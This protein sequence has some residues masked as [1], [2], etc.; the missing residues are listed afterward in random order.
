MCPVCLAALKDPV[1]TRCGHRF[2]KVCLRQCVHSSRYGRCPVDNMWFDQRR[3]VFCDVAIGREVLS[4]TVRC[5]YHPQDCP[6]TGEL[7]ALQRHST[8][9]PH[10][11]VVC[12][13]E[14]G[15][16]C[17]RLELVDHVLECPRRLAV[18]Q[19]CHEEVVIAELPKHQL[20]ACQKFPVNCTICG[21]TGILRGDI[22]R[23]INLMSGNCPLVVVKCPYEHIGCC[24]QDKRKNM[25]TH[26]KQASDHH[27][28]LLSMKLAQQDETILRQNT[29][30]EQLVQSCHHLS[31]VIRQ[32]EDNIRNHSRILEE[33]ESDIYEMSSSSWNGELHWKVSIPEDQSQTIHS[34]TFFTGRPGYKFQVGLD[35]HGLRDG[36]EWFSTVKLIL[37]KGHMDNLL[38]FP[39]EI[40]CKLCVVDPHTAGRRLL[41]SILEIDGLS[42]AVSESSPTT[43]TSHTLMATKRLLTHYVKDNVIFIHAKIKIVL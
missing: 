42:Q 24:F 43:S 6:W 19:H 36:G 12:S 41:K 8:S 14:C 4:L 1:Q 15:V 25:A 11:P 18:C 10:A 35:I 27:V 7:R 22:S 39:V 21:Q 17:K 13:N 23:H 5:D 16:T 31:N 37:L 28:L 38:R 33:V 3:D 34:Q 29:N 2:C 32:Q 20:L 40:T 30:I 26:H 9:C